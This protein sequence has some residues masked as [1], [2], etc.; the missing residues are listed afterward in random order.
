MEDMPKV[1]MRTSMLSEKI[2]ILERLARNLTVYFD[3]FHLEP[4]V[5]CNLYG[6]LK[7]MHLLQDEKHVSVEKG[8]LIVLFIIYHT[9]RQRVVGD[10]F[11]HLIWT[12]ST[13]FKKVLRVVCT[14]Q[15]KI[16]HPRK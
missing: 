16:I 6:K 13:W 3:N 1:P 9:K 15:T 7:I 2:Y 12:I 5:F 11:Q 8:V 14:L 4:Y 10:I